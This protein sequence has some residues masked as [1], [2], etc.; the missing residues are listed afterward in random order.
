MAEESKSP[1]LP[2]AKGVYLC[3][4][5]IGYENGKTDLYGLFN[6][7]RPQKYPHTQGRF[8]VFAQ[9]VNGLGQ[10]SF[11]IDVRNASR[12]ELVHTTQTHQLSFPD[13]NTLVQMVL[14]IEQCPFPQPG[15]YLVELFCDNKWVSDTSLLLP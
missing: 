7:I 15:I 8:C 4:Y 11:H 9:L 1:I 14:T 2:V 5:V 13:R 10:I 6:A 3:D 12:D